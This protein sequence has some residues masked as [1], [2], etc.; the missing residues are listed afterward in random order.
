M[1]RA[2]PR[3]ISIPF[4]H[5]SEKARWALDHH[6]RSY[7][8]EGHPPVL[9]IVAVRRA[10]GSRTAPVLVLDDRVLDD[11]T[12][13]L[14]PLDAGRADTPRLYPEL[15]GDTV[16]ELEDL[17][18][19]RLG[20]ATRRIGYGQLLRYPAIV[21][22]SFPIGVGSVEALL[23][24]AFS[25]LLIAA[26]RR[27]LRIDEAGVTRSSAVATELFDQVAGRLADG[28]P[29][30]AG[31]QLSA[32]DLTFAALSGP[33]LLPPGCPTTLPPYEAMPEPIRDLVDRY[34]ATPAGEFGLRLYALDRPARPPGCK[35]PATM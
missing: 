32:A 33:L 31:D 26:I 6:R 19:R 14:A 21:R 7:R 5:Y 34:R 17:F 28:R 30:L 24:R 10:G 8:E 4:S 25:P 23:S 3:L 12:A 11:S 18:D 2:V 27:A 9:H 20:P 15:G 16:R 13:I 35:E 1:S 29:Y 22:R